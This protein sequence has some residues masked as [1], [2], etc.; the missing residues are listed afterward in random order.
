MKWNA[1][2]VSTPAAVKGIA[3]LP[4]PLHHLPADRVMALHRSRAIR[5]SIDPV[6]MTWS[7]RS[8]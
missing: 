4:R 7:Q 2:T 5:L 3:D 8:R 1:N 6:A